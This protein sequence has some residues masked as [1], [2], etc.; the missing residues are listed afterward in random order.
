MMSAMGVASRMFWPL[1]CTR[2]WRLATKSS[3]KSALQHVFSMGTTSLQVVCASAQW[4][5]RAWHPG[6]NCTC[7]ESL[8]QSNASL[9]FFGKFARWTMCFHMESADI[10]CDDREFHTFFSSFPLHMLALSCLMPRCKSSLFQ[11]W[12]GQ[13]W[14]RTPVSQVTKSCLKTTMKIK[15][16]MCIYGLHCSIYHCNALSIVQDVMQGTDLYIYMFRVSH[17]QTSLEKHCTNVSSQT[18]IVLDYSLYT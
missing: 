7:R 18:C 6:V 1:C 3:L 8:I 5:S 12:T 2:F 13:C 10:L 15:L 4:T 14:P 17:W 9:T 11:H 16:Q